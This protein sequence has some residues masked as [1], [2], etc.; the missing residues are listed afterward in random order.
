MVEI[1][2]APAD[3]APLLLASTLEGLGLAAEV[4]FTPSK[5]ATGT[6]EPVSIN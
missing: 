3:G 5:E 1:L 4:L 2:G 6:L